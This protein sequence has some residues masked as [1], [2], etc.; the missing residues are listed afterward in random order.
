MR[1]IKLTFQLD[2]P[3]N[4]CRAAS[5][6]LAMFLLGATQ[7]LEVGIRVELNSLIVIIPSLLTDLYKSIEPRRSVS[8]FLHKN[9][10]KG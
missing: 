10:I 2:F 7:Q 6:I 5:A 4:L 1:Q 8:R 9:V 3:G